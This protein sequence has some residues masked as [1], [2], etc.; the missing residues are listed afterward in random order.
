M[1][2]VKDTN[3]AK[4]RRSVELWKV[5]NRQYYLCQK[6]RLSSRPE[7]L[8]HRREMYR[9]VRPIDQTPYLSTNQ[10]LDLQHDA[11]QSNEEGAG[12]SHR[13]RSDTEN[14]EEWSRANTAVRQAAEGIGLAGGH[15]H[16]CR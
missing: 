5:R 14:P 12:F 13:G 3:W 7:Y 1:E 6:R 11:P 9:A 8:A 10:T 16:K 4:H 15:S 2:L